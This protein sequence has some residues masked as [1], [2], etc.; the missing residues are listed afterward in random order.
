M[1]PANSRHRTDT[2]AAAL[3]SEAKRLGVEYADLGGTID[4]VIWLGPVTR[5]VDFKSATGGLTG[6]QAKLVARGLP[7][8]FVS[9]VGQLEALV[10]AMKRE[11]QGEG[12]R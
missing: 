8:A 2:T 4:G 5:L 3:R 9:S 1:K 11:S 10:S 7:I 6:S 12:Q